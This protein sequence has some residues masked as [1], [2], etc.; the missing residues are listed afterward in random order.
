MPRGRQA[1]AARNDRAVLDAARE[2]FAR[3]GYDAPM[4]AVAERAG[5]GVASLYRRFETKEAMLRHLCVASLRE[6]AEAA[7]RALDDRDPWRGLCEYVRACVGFSA[8]SFSSIAGAVEPTAEMTRL[9]RQ[10]LR[11]VEELAR[12]AH[13]DGSLRE[14]ATAMDVVWLIEHF[15]RSATA[16]EP[17]VRDRQLA[18]ALSGLRARGR[19]PL[20][21]P[22]PRARD[23]RAR[24]DSAR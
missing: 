4:S 23:Y 7:G 17:A 13:A 10:V 3:H 15:S 16:P 19:E 1:E 6:N 5:V 24:W 9:A 8:G 18:I 20:P 14:D 11:Q 21:S 22:A 12:R 2:V